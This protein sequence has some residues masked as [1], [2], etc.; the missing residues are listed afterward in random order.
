MA[1]TRRGAISS[2]GHA[3]CGR[4]LFGKTVPRRFHPNYKFIRSSFGA[5]R[6]L[7]VTR[8]SMMV[9]VA[10][11]QKSDL[12]PRKWILLPL[13]VLLVAAGLL[14]FWSPIPLGL[15]LIILGL[16]MLLRYSPRARPGGQ[17]TYEDDFFGGFRPD[18]SSSQPPSRT[19]GRLRTCPMLIHSSA[20]GPRWASGSRTNSTRKRKTP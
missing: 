15:P 2:A 16:P 12:S 20:T 1:G 11:P 8:Q 3:A 13:G 14:L 10:P 7:P 9:P 5:F 18:R 4:R 17:L 6:L 19:M